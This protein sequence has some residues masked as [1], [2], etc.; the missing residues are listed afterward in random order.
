LNLYVD[1]Q[2][3]KRAS[4]TDVNVTWNYE[5]SSWPMNDGTD[6]VAISWSGDYTINENSVVARVDYGSSSLHYYRDMDVS[7]DVAHN[8]FAVNV[9]CRNILRVLVVLN[10]WPL[11]IQETVHLL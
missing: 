9:I 6:G 2:V 1:A 10:I 8:G 3:V 4:R 5:W 11:H 7:F